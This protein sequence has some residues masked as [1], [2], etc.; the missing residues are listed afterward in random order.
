MS[1]VKINY[2]HFYD[3]GL[4]PPKWAIQVFFVSLVNKRVDSEVAR[5]ERIPYKINYYPLH[6]FS[7]E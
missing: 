7:I 6:D 2:N 4:V 1:V 5:Q 3:C